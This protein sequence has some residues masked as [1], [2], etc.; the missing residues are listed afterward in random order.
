[1]KRAHINF[2]AM[3]LT[4]MLSSM[5]AGQG[6]QGCE[7]YSTDTD[8]CADFT[9]QSCSGRLNNVIQ[10]DEGDG[11]QGIIYSTLACTPVG[12]CKPGTCTQCVSYPNIPVA[13][14]NDA[15][16][17]GGGGGSCCTCDD[18]T[19]APHCCT[20]VK[21]V[22][23]KTCGETPILL[24][25]LFFDP[26]RPDSRVA[27]EQTKNQIE[28]AWLR[29]RGPQRVAQKARKSQDLDRIL[30]KVKSSQGQSSAKAGPQTAGRV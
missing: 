7:L 30:D 28:D 15:C 20:D 21:G 1:M 13:V 24:S 18:G 12:N 22:K 10:Y 23:A 27:E 4:L 16:I 6:P 5:A 3:L 14:E 9:N 2:L 29:A 11:I 8:T 26:N 19:C 25:Q 17:G